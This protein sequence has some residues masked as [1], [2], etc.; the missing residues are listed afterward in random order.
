MYRWRTGRRNG[1]NI[2]PAS[3]SPP[4]HSSRSQ[5][6]CALIKIPS[7]LSRF[8]AKIRRSSP[9]LLRLR[10]DSSGFSPF[11]FSF[12]M[13]NHVM[14]SYVSLYCFLRLIVCFIEFVFGIWIK[15]EHC[16]RSYRLSQWVLDS[17]SCYRYFVFN[18]IRIVLYRYAFW[19]FDSVESSLRIG[20]LLNPNY[21]R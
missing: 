2:S 21:F 10:F 9:S 15:F 4:L 6:I 5:I 18:C 8:S 20:W 11:S 19:C 13:Y 16:R 17:V 14:C 3:A 12:W 1:G 7:L